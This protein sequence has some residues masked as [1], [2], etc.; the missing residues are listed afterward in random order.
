MR[1]RSHELYDE[2]VPKLA[3][4]DSINEMQILAYLYKCDPDN[5]RRN[6][7]TWNAV[8]YD[9]FVNIEQKFI[10]TK[11]A[12]TTDFMLYEIIEER[13]KKSSAFREGW[14]RRF[15]K[16]IPDTLEETIAFYLECRDLSQAERDNLIGQIKSL[17]KNYDDNSYL[18]L[19]PRDGKDLSFWLSDDVFENL[20]TRRDNIFFE[21]LD[22]YKDTGYLKNH[23]IIVKITEEIHKRVKNKKLSVQNLHYAYVF[24]QKNKIADNGI[25]D[26]IC[27]RLNVVALYSGFDAKDYLSRGELVKLWRKAL[28]KDSGL[29]YKNSKFFKDNYPELYCDAKLQQKTTQCFI[30]YI[31][32][33]TGST[34]IHA[35]DRARMI[36]SY[37]FKE[38]LYEILPVF[39]DLD[40]I[41]ILLDPGCIE[42]RDTLVMKSFCYHLCRHGVKGTISMGAL[43]DMSMSDLP[44]RQR[45]VK[46]VIMMLIFK[47]GVQIG[48]YSLRTLF[49]QLIQNGD[50]R[51]VEAVMAKYIRLNTSTKAVANI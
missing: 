49:D 5:Y 13:I 12:S 4:S 31:N 18:W 3:K 44:Y 34:A 10:S 42:W 6:H 7:F 19:L 50:R 8:L 38:I 47:A 29:L 14:F 24:L 25:R 37:S 48:S 21:A 35:Y 46:N 15:S 2:D 41:S 26:R 28:N 16:L 1:K 23:R 32:S 39:K 33:T 9:A 51:F 20:K 27:K 30:E 36:A 11:K 40:L 43:I 17:I 22:N 45:L